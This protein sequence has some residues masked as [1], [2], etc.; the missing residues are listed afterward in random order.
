MAEHTP[1]DSP[2]AGYSRPTSLHEE[3]SPVSGATTPTMANLFNSK[4]R[5]RV[6]LSKVVKYDVDHRKRSY[7]P[8]RID[9]HYDRLHNPDNCYHIRLDWLNVTAKLI[10]D[11]VEGWAR[12]AANYG[13][14]LVEVPIREACTITDTNPFRRP[15]TIK[16]AI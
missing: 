4:K 10:E 16:L 14:R 2:R 11:A 12:E 15:Y 7:R 8:E 3:H 5:P 6:V 9:L 13:L 1:K